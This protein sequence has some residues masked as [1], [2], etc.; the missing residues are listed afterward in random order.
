[1]SP[2]A[3][4]TAVD[5]ASGGSGPV[6]R[7]RTDELLPLAKAAVAGDEDA[8]GT[9]VGHLGRS[10]LAV[11]RR[12][13]GRQCPDVDDVTQDA[14][15][16]VLDG[17]ASFRGECTVFHF[18]QRIALLTALTAQRRIRLRE[19]WTTD[20]DAPT[21]AVACASAESP[22]AS[23]AARLR[24]ALVRDLLGELPDA[25]AESLGMH[26]ALGYTVDE[27]AVAAGIS[28]NTVWSRLRLGKQALRRKLAG[29]P[30]LAE[31]LEVWP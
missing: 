2:I 8:A 5:S 28:P 31:R 17:L 14:V 20:A 16:A 27:I 30:R 23:A 6:G 9:L 15:I 12:V 26:Y 7:A 4:A 22:M 24:R 29:D 25:I 19:R 11:V 13:L 3:K 21:D 1:M 10:L 18:A